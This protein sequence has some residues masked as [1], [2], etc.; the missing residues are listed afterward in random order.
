MVPI[1]G[2]VTWSS[3]RISRRKASNSGSARSTSSISR[4]TR[5]EEGAGDEEALVEEGGLAPRHPVRR[6]GERRRPAD[7]L[8]HGVAEELRVEHLLGVVPLV[9]RLRLVEPLVA[10]EAEQRPP[11]RLGHRPGEVRLPD[12]GRALAEQRPRHS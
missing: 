4:T 6:L 11:Q 7:V 12:A 3:L 5:G 9:E 2:I 8:C 10:L 1:S